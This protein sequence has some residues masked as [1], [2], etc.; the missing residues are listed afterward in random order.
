MLDIIESVNE[1][2]LYTGDMSSD[3]GLVRNLTHALEIVGGL[4]RP[5]KMPCYC[6]NL[7]ASRCKMGGKLNAVPGSVCYGCYAADD[8]DWVKRKNAANGKW[9]LTRYTMHTVQR[10]LSRRFDSL[11]N[12]LWVPAMVYAINHYARKGSD[13]F[14]WHDSGDIQDSNH[15]SNIVSVCEH[16]PGV[17]HWLPT[18]EYAIVRGVSTPEN[19]CVRLSAHMVDASPP[20]FGMPTSTVSTGDPVAGVRCNAPLNEGKCGSCRLCWNRNVQNIDYHHH[21]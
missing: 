5:D 21:N 1:V 20:D 8:M 12:P 9:V 13:H 19:L 18:R 14:R 6:Y 10:A 16:T 7:P 15:F 4:S 17:K 11:N 2:A 3:I